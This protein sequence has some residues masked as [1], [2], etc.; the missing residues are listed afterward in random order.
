[1]NNLPVNVKKENIFRKCINFIKKIFNRERVYS[2]NEAVNVNYS[3]QREKEI[4]NLYKVN[5]IEKVYIEKEKACKMKEI[6]RIIED[7]PSV[8]EKLDINRLKIID[9]YYVE[10]IE[11]CKKKLTSISST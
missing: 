11:K 2:D 6:I 5:N 7:N 9:N 1:M 4:D 8:L 3:V 10:K